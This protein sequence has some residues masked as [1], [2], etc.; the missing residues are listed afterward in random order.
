M[1]AEMETRTRA[2]ELQ[3]FSDFSGLPLKDVLSLPQSSI[4]ALY[5]QTN[6]II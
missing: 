3:Q 2:W 4:T 5:K 1:Q 6:Y